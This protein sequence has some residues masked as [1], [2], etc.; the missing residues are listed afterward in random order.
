MR[1][2]HY[3]QILEPPQLWILGPGQVSLPPAHTVINIQG[4]YLQYA[5]P[6]PKSIIIIIAH[7]PSPW[8]FS[9]VVMVLLY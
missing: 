1:D 4:E 7:N 9:I 3:F 2:F 5:A 8:K 6:L